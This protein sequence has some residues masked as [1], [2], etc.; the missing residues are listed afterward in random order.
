M[1][2][3]KIVVLDGHT[4]TPADAEGLTPEGEPSWEAMRGLGGL[5]VYPRTQAER[6]VERVGDAS[7][8][9]TNKAP[10]PAERIAALPGLKYIGVMATGTNVVDLVA[11]KEAGVVVTNVPSYSTASVAQHVFAMA[12]SINAAMCETHAAVQRGGWV[13]SDDFSFT[14]RPWR[15]LAGRALGIV[16][17]GEI[18]TAVAKLG[19]AFGMEVY[20]HSRTRKDVGVPVHWLGLDEL[21][22]AADIVSLHCPL[23]E[24]TQHLVD[25]R[26]HDEPHQSGA[27]H[28]RDPGR[29][30]RRW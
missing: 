20:V 25:E 28:G 8:V 27:G 29:G 6:I 9:L 4:L 13:G 11:A 10:M 23:T 22:Q 14:V 17:L 1:T 21:F 24:E 5:R 30:R 26:R 3:P 2:T 16:G 18:G 15:E 19:Q 12:L 7:V